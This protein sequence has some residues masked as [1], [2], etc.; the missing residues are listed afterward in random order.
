LRAPSPY[1]RSS[2]RPGAS[3]VYSAA[4][5][6]AITLALSGAVYS[7]AD[8]H[9][10]PVPAYALSS[11]SVYGEPS[12]LHIRVNSS[13][14]TRPAEFRVDNASSVAGVIALDLRGFSV[15]ESLCAAGLTTFFSVLSGTGIISVSGAG[16]SWVDGV[17]TSTSTVQSGWHE[18]IIE[19]GSG[20]GV[21]LPGGAMVR[22]PSPSLS[23]IPMESSSSASFVFIVP[24]FTGGHVAT[25]VF[26]GGSQVLDF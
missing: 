13:A 20:C 11:Y 14:P 7:L 12:F 24:Y 4:L 9:V 19:D 10:T 15:V 26:D 25:I 1:R 21:A 6:V 18:I 2:T 17:E 8:F 22:G 3:E 16:V 23:T 5:L